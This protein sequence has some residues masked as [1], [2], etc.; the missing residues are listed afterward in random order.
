VEGADAL[1]E[2]STHS[3]ALAARRRG[4][5]HARAHDDHYLVGKDTERPR[6]LIA[7]RMGIAPLPAPSPWSS[8][9]DGSTL[10]NILSAKRRGPAPPQVLHAQVSLGVKSSTFLPFARAGLEGNTVLSPEGSAA[11]VGS[12]RGVIIS[13][14]GEALPLAASEAASATSDGEDAHPMAD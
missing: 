6:A 13:S 8:G 7:Q 4:T 5:E 10:Q 9:V 12:A 2:A 3:H 11:R 1:A 14:A